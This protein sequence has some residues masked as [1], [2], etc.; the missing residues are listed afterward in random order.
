MGGIEG[1]SK[2]YRLKKIN[3]FWVNLSL[4]KEQVESVLPL[5]LPK[6]RTCRL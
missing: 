2:V 6:L 5:F 1:I 3:P 4:H